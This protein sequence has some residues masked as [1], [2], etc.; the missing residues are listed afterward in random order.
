MIP[1]KTS[2]V[3]NL[4][5]KLSQSQLATPKELTPGPGSYDANTNFAKPRPVSAILSSKSKRNLPIEPY[6]ISRNL[7]ISRGEQTKSRRR[8]NAGKQ[9]VYPENTPGPGSYTLRNNSNSKERKIEN[10]V[11]S[12]KPRFKYDDSVR[13]DSIGPGHQPIDSSRFASNSFAKSS[14]YEKPKR[15][16]NPGP[17]SYNFSINHIKPKMGM[18]SF[19]KSPKLGLYSKQQKSLGPGEYSVNESFTKSIRNLGGYSFGT[20]EKKSSICKF[21]F[22]KKIGVGNGSYIKIKQNQHSPTKSMA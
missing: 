8:L 11:F 18:Y 7:S 14:K 20:A 21:D 15:E 17:G 6:S 16:D 2:V 1:K 3:I 22:E 13:D 10:V 5:D 19:S 9:I 12:K 4:Q